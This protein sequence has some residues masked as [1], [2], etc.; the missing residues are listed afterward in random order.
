MLPQCAR[1]VL[2]R[3][4]A[5][6]LPVA[7]VMAV[8]PPKYPFLSL[9]A[10]SCARCAARFFVL[11]VFSSAD[12]HAQALARVPSLF[13][14]ASTWSTLPALVGQAMPRKSMFSHVIKKFLG[15]RFVFTRSVVPYAMAIDA[16]TVVVGRAASSALALAKRLASW[17]RHRLVFATLRMSSRVLAVR[18][19]GRSSPSTLIAATTQ[20]LGVQQVQWPSSR[21]KHVGLVNETSNT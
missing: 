4:E 19:A 21:R 6:S 15:L 12:D 18:G 13:D 9:F 17:E 2:D 20:S 16:E 1:R 7:L 8:H 3:V 5:D 11:P 14:E 10:V